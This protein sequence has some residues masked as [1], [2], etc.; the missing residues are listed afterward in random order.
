MKYFWIRQMWTPSAG[1]MTR[2]S[3]YLSAVSRDAT[4]IPTGHPERYLEIFATIY[5]GAVEAIRISIQF[6]DFSAY[7]ILSGIR[8]A[9]KIANARL[10]ESTK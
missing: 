1:P 2:A 6:R 8:A 7:S 3:G 4:R 5:C 9:V 10:G